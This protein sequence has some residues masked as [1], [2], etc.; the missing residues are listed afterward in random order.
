MGQ[1][2]KIPVYVNAVQYVSTNGDNGLQ[3]AINWAVADGAKIEIMA[4]IPHLSSTL[5]W[6]PMQAGYWIVKHGAGAYSME[7]P[8]SFQQ[9][10]IPVP[11]APNS[12]T[13]EQV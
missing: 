4:G 10:Y 8:M 1:Y 7:H 6:M 13:P 9:T 5:G 12:D 11:G 2:M 3:E